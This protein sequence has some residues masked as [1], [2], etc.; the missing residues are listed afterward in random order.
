[1]SAELLTINFPWAEIHCDLYNKAIKRKLR[2][3]GC[4]KHGSVTLPI[5]TGM[6]WVESLVGAWIANFPLQLLN[7]CWPH[8][9]ECAPQCAIYSRHMFNLCSAG[10]FRLC[11]FVFIAFDYAEEREMRIYETKCIRVQLLVGTLTKLLAYNQISCTPK[12]FLYF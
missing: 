7:I 1:M 3:P 10:S 12:K 11:S 4:V 8:G 6:H 2:H 9:N 5:N